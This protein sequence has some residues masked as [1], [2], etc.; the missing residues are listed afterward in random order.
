MQLL[1][2]RI[3]CCCI[4]HRE[5][6]SII[7]KR[8]PS[9]RIHCRVLHHQYDFLSPSRTAV[10]GAHYGGYV[11]TYTLANDPDNVFAC[12]IAIS[13]VCKWQILGIG[14][15]PSFVTSILSSN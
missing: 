6:K 10:I 7:H 15:E 14:R 12:G 5:N 3:L 8:V 9:G 1:A 2:F 13:P 4:E 11:A